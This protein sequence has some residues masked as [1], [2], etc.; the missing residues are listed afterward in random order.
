[1]KASDCSA[2]EVSHLLSCKITNDCSETINGAYRTDNKKKLELIEGDEVADVT[3]MNTF[4]G[5]QNSNSSV[6][7]GDYDEE[8]KTESHT[9]KVMRLWKDVHY[10]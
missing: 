2:T 8:F 5:N 9:K 1:M 7:K 10:T 4:T 3:F 6:M